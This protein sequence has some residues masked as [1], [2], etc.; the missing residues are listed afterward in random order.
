MSLGWESALHQV[1][2]DSTGAGREMLLALGAERQ[3]LDSRDVSGLED[4]ADRK[5]HLTASLEKLEQERKM[6]MD[7]QDFSGNLSHDLN[8]ADPVQADLLDDWETFLAVLSECRHQN[9]VNGLIVK[10]QRQHLQQ[11]LTI[12]R[13]ERSE[14][15]TYSSEGAAI[16]QSHGRVLASA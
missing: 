7:S 5:N 6:L 10:R 8:R 2:S 16:Q 11:M 9:S 14:P 12:V 4:A 3:A 13:G 15:G 1:L